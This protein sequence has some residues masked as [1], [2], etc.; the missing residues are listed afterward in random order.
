[1]KKQKLYILLLI[2]TIGCSLKSS[3]ESKFEG[4]LPKEDLIM[5]NRLVEKFDELIENKYEGN[6]PDF[7]NS[8]AE[9]ESITEIVNK[10]SD[11]QILLAFEKSTLEYK[12]EKLQYD[13]V[14]A[15]NYYK[16]GEEELFSED[17][18]IMTVTQDRDTS[19]GDIVVIGEQTTQKK[20]EEIKKQGYWN[21]ISE[22]SF[23][24]ALTE[25][26][27]ENQEIDEYL[28]RRQAVGEL[29]PKSMANALL[30]FKIDVNSYFIKRI[31]VFE[32][33]RQ[34]IKREHGC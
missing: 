4:N 31:I 22:S 28:D 12:G 21:H 26:K 13:T 8:V 5:L 19:W 20:I 16:I 23:V 7:L 33:F 10:N 9:G 32:I 30:E 29:N 25:T 27:I 3:I 15:S 11:C 18:I 14:Y 24:R 17:L 2:L 1:M 34:Q 6:I